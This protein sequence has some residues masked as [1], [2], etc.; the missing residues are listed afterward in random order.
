MSELSPA[1]SPC[2]LPAF[3]FQLSL[4]SRFDDCSSCISSLEFQ[5][6]VTYKP[7]LLFCSTVLFSATTHSLALNLWGRS[8]ENR[9]PH[10]FQQQVTTKA[11][12]LTERQSLR[13]SVKIDLSKQHTDC[14]MISVTKSQ[15][16]A[17][18][19]KLPENFFTF[20]LYFCISLCFEMNKT[21]TPYRHLGS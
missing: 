1:L 19:H 12:L 20:S 6:D 17:I 11:L 21:N 15:I 3:F 5:L 10:G 14:L 13:F 2:Q 4:C 7:E 18:R 9:A 16:P 8:A